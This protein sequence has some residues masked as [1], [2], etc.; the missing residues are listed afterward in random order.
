M[1]YPEEK[2]AEIQ[3]AVK[4]RDLDFVRTFLASSKH[5]GITR[6]TMYAACLFDDVEVVEMCMKAGWLYDYYT[7]LTALHEGATKVADFLYEKARDRDLN[8]YLKS[9]L[10]FGG[11]N[12]SVKKCT[13]ARWLI[14]HGYKF[15]HSDLRAFAIW[16]E[17]DV[18]NI[19]FDSMTCAPMCVPRY[20]EMFDDCIRNGAFRVAQFFEC[21]MGFDANQVCAEEEMLKA[22]KDRCTLVRHAAIMIQMKWQNYRRRKDPSIALKEAAESWNKLVAEFPEKFV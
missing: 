19:I 15:G 5:S 8:K 17:F 22:Y 14:A 10:V 20:K 7:I 18:F 1:S 9:F 12:S 13:T 3:L 11:C 2:L 21:V 16:D 6:R 4:R